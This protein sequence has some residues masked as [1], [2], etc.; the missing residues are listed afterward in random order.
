MRQINK[1]NTL[2]ENFKAECGKSALYSE[3][4]NE[5]TSVVV[6]ELLY[7][8]ALYVDPESDGISMIYEHR[9]C[10]ANIHAALAAIQLYKKTG[11][12][13]LWQKDHSNQISVADGH[14]YA[15]GVLHSPEF[16]LGLAGWNEKAVAKGDFKLT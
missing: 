4:I 6:V 13:L 7:H 2:F 12:W 15:A 9:Y 14:L 8:V 10:Y 1:K 16:S 3:V 11:Q 5:E